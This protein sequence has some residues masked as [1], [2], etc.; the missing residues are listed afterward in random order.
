MANLAGVALTRVILFL[1]SYAPLFL[2]TGDSEL[3]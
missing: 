3:G 1:S 2:I